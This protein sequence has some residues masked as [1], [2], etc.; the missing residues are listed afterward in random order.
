MERKTA[1]NKDLEKFR[2][3]IM[4]DESFRNKLN[5]RVEAYHGEQTEEAVFNNVLVPVL[6]EYSITITMEDLE[7]YA[8]S[9]V[10]IDIEDELAQVS[11]GESSA[12]GIFGGTCI[13]AGVGLGGSFGKDGGLICVMIG[14]GWGNSNCLG[15]GVSEK[16]V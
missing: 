10:N 15:K 12:Y 6:E 7:E 1:M 2:E 5:D 13:G 8:S 11:G 9:M 16:V 3:L 14:V 4:T